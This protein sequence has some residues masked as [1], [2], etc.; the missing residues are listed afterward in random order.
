MLKKIIPVLFLLVGIGAGVGAGI[1]LG[2]DPT[3][4]SDEQTEHVPTDSHE[5]PAGEP[6]YVKLNNQ[7]VVPVVSGDQVSALVVMTLSLETVPGMTE[8]IYSREP[9]LRDAFLQV[10]FDH[11]NMGGFD[12]S[13]TSSNTLDTLRTALREVA[14][15]EFGNDISNVLIVGIARQDV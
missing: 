4:N 3:D 7:F 9:K 14:Q 8:T 2:V 10:M 11:A 12:G 15:L 13:F 6:E 1:F 5:T